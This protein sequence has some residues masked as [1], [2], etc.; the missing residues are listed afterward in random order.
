MRQTDAVVRYGGEEFLLVLADVSLAT[1]QRIAERAR[2]AVETAVVRA[3]DVDVQVTV[4][5]GLAERRPGEGRGELIER[6]DAA[7]YRAKTGG[8]NRVEVDR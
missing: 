8:R 7:M 6:A 2:K 1:A 3:G 5:I 4:S